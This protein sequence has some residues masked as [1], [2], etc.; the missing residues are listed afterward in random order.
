MKAK[1]KKTMMENLIKSNPQYAQAW[2]VTQQ[3]VNGAGSAQDKI[4]EACKKSGTDT[5]VVQKVLNSL[6]IKF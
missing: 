4:N 5:N 1:D 3:I 2:E 6:G